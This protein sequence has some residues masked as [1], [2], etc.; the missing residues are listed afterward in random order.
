MEPRPDARSVVMGQPTEVRNHGWTFLTNHGHVLLVLA[1]DPGLRIRDVAAQ[2]GI[3]ERAAQRILGDLIAAGYLVRQK[4]GRRNTYRLVLDRPLRHPIE[5]PHRVR[6]LI[7][8]L[9][10]S[11]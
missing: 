3:T 7:E 4:Q 6:E 1:T 2:V 5:A 11:T 9:R 10:I 8:A